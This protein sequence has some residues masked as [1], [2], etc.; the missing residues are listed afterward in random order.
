[1]ETRLPQGKKIKFCLYARKSSERDELQ[2]LSIDAQVKE[3]MEIADRDGLNVVDIRKESHS[4][5]D[6]GERPVFRSI[7]NDIKLDKIQGILTW[8]PDRLSRNA[9]DLGTLVDLMDQ[10]FL[11]EIRTYSQVFTNSPNDKFLLMILGSQAK[12]ENDNKAINVKRG[13]KAK[14]EMGYRPGMTPLGYINDKHA[15]KGQRKVYLDPVRAPIIK[16]MFEKVVYEDCSGRDLYIWLKEVGFTSRGG[17]SVSLST[18]YEMLKSTYYYGSFEYPVGSGNW[19]EVAHESIITKEL[20]EEAQMCLAVAPRSR[21][22]MKEF[23]FTNLIKCGNCGSGICAEEKFKKLKDGSIKRYVYYHCTRGAD[24]T[25]KEHSILEEDLIEQLQRVIDE[26]PLNKL[27]AQTKLQEEFNR[28]KMFT[29]KVLKQDQ[30]EANIPDLDLRSFAK[31]I[32]REGNRDEKRELLA[33][34]RTSL[35]LK[36]K[37]IYIK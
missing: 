6:S 32:L 26:I 34:L 5:K 27:R 4:A 10:K 17:K 31:Y 25:C 28:H 18:I 20:F 21:F 7:I 23:E 24:R 16:Q 12:L 15:Q 19:Y 1:M 11:I 2:A 33:C 30:P 3:M 37:T 14:C 35:Q 36:S 22:G 13:L 8:A 9:G 29:E